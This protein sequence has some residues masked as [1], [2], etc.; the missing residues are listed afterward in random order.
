MK[1]EDPP[2]IK[3]G[4]LSVS[5]PPDRRTDMSPPKWYWTECTDAEVTIPVHVR[6]DAHPVKFDYIVEIG[7]SYDGSGE[8]KTRQYTIHID[9]G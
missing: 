9:N 7:Q 4:E 5:P 6:Q 3:I 1:H 2:N 8:S